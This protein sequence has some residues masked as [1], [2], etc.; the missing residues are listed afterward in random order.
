MKALIALEQQRY[1]E[2]EQAKLEQ[3]QTMFEA[4][5]AAAKAAKPVSDSYITFGAQPETQN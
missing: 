3:Q 2:L 1:Y 5:Q 4:Q